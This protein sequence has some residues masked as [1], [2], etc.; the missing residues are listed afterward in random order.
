[1]SFIKRAQYFSSSLAFLGGKKVFLLSISLSWKVF[2]SFSLCVQLHLIWKAIKDECRMFFSSFRLWGRQTWGTEREWKYFSVHVLAWVWWLFVACSLW[3]S[4]ISAFRAVDNCCVLLQGENGNQKAVEVVAGWTIS[5]LHGFV[6]C[7]PNVY[8]PSTGLS[9]TG[10]FQHSEKWFNILMLVYECTMCCNIPTVSDNL[11]TQI[12][13]DAH[14][15]FTN[16]IT[17]KS[18]VKLY[19]LASWWGN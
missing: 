6:P 17:A 14:V 1:M 19:E 16:S 13:A 12:D 10:N 5:C 3:R 11:C 15:I 4:L 2:R 8:E 18:I 9:C 7:M